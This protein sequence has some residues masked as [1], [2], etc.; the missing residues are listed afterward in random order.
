MS[1]LVARLGTRHERSNLCFGYNRILNGIVYTL[2]L[3]EAQL[4]GLIDE[5][6][7]YPL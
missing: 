1:R 6:I 3:S 4:R 5:S 2:N 7:L